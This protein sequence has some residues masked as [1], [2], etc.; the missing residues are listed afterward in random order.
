[1]SAFKNGWIEKTLTIKSTSVGG[2]PGIPLLQSCKNLLQGILLHILTP[3]DLKIIADTVIFSS[4]VDAMYDDM[5]G[6]FGYESEFEK[7]NDGCG[8]DPL[9]IGSVMRIYLLR[10][11][12]ELVVNGIREDYEISK[13]LN[14]RVESFDQGDKNKFGKV[15]MD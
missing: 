4:S 15:T 6:Q 8:E 11:L 2:D 14:D 7:T 9:S 1:M 13:L 12:E 5:C 3:E 10:L